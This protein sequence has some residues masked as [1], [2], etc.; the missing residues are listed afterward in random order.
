MIWGAEKA[1]SLIAITPDRNADKMVTTTKKFGEFSIAIENE[2]EPGNV[3][4][5]SGKIK[6]HSGA[7]KK[8]CTFD[9]K[10]FGDGI[11]LASNFNTLLLASSGP[12]DSSIELYDTKTCKRMSEVFFGTA[13]VGPPAQIRRKP[14]CHP[15]CGKTCGCWPAKIYTAD[16]NCKF[17]LQRKESQ[18]LTKAAFGVIF[19]K[20]REVPLGDPVV[21]KN[22]PAGF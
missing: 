7:N 3:S 10:S 6:T 22:K 21:E 4:P 11:W 5:D 12:E 19:D 20:K 9:K 13:E 16:S 1:C 17:I 8:E 2:Y 18:E 14:Y 15:Q